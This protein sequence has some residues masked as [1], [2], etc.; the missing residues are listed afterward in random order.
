MMLPVAIL[1]GGLGTRL[2]PL[3]ETIPKCLI[4]VAGRPFIVH[5]LELLRRQGIERA[6][7]CLGHLGSMVEDLLGRGNGL[8]ARGRS[9]LLTSQWAE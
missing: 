7:L 5:Q 4:E 6:V 9:E 1:A 2:R 3:T 8:A